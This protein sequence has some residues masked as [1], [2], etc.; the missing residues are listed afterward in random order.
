MFGETPLARGTHRAGEFVQFAS[1]CSVVDERRIVVVDG[2][3]FARADLATVNALA[4]MQ[5]AA[6]RLGW[7][8][9]LRN[10]TPELSALLTFVGLADLFGLCVDAGR[11]AE[12]GEQ[13]GVEEVVETG[14]APA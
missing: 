13:L 9:R 5:L 8:L 12:G 14:D 7:T 4:R 1:S 6:R 10:P 3:S 11:Q 2:A